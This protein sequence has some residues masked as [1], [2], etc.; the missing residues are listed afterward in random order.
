MFDSPSTWAVCFQQLVLLI[1]GQFQ[2]AN[3]GVG[4]SLGQ[5]V[6]NDRGHPSHDC[7]PGYAR[8]FLA[9]DFVEPRFHQRIGSQDMP[10]GLT[11]YPPSHPAAGLGDVTQALLVTAAARARR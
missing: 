3:F 11:E 9:F 1:R 7:H 10:T 2:R 5:H 4:F 8:T 6:P